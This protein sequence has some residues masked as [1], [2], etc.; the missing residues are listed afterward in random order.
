MLT[1]A[2]VAPNHDAVADQFHIDE[3]SANE[4][5]WRIASAFIPPRIRVPRLAVLALLDQL[6]G[7]AGA[8][9]P[10]R[11]AAG[12]IRQQFLL[13]ELLR[14][15]ASP[16][17][18]PLVRTVV[19]A[20]PPIVRAEIAAF[21]P[22]LLADPVADSADRP[23]SV[24]VLLSRIN[25]RGTAWARLFQALTG[26][27]ASAAA[28]GLAAA[29]RGWRRRALV[30]PLSVV[31]QFPGDAETTADDRQQALGISI[32]QA[33]ADISPVGPTEAL[34]NVVAREQLRAAL[35]QQ[36]SFGP[37]LAWRCWRAVRRLPAAE[38]NRWLG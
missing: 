29:S 22:E 34:A 15:P 32:L 19:R 24:A 35:A 28:S 23:A 10:E 14:P 12:H 3:W 1:I 31:A 36:Q 26:E 25:A 30:M 21:G 13:E 17:S 8:A 18:H 27:P 16:S 5:A 37:L 6:D 9:A 7:S 4:P 33:F 11:Q 38:R 20:A 2:A